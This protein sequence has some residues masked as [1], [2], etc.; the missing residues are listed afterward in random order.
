M[1]P[2]LRGLRA[3]GVLICLFLLPLPGL[4]AGCTGGG[5][6][7]SFAS[8]YQAVF[9]D[10]GQ[11]FFGKIGEA[12]PDY[13]TLKDVYFVQRQ[14]EPDKKARNILMRLGS[15]WHGPDFM[16]INNRHIVRLEPVAPDSQVAKLIREAKAAPAAATAP[17]PTATTPAPAAAP[18]KGEKKAAP[19]RR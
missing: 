3:F 1:Q 10:N 15:E 18:G 13:L 6:D 9:L 19:A 14:V 16:R 5:S 8:E 11:I 17:P 12:S 4:V 2:P 7:L